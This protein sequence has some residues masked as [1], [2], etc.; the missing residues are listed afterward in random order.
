MHVSG[1]TF[2]S[3]SAVLED[4]WPEDI[5]FEN[6]WPFFQAARDFV[7]AEATAYED[8]EDV[9]WRVLSMDLSTSVDLDDRR[10]HEQ[11]RLAFYDLEAQLQREPDLESRRMSTATMEYFAS[12]MKLQYK[13]EAVPDLERIHRRRASGLEGG[14]PSV[15]P[16][17]TFISTHPT[18]QYWPAKTGLRLSVRRGFMASWMES[19]SPR[20]PPRRRSFFN[21]TIT[22]RPSKP[23][24]TRAW[25][26]NTLGKIDFPACRNRVPGPGY[27]VFSATCGTTS[28]KPAVS[29]S[30]PA[31]VLEDEIE[32]GWFKE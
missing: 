18:A 12:C 30:H 7:R 27:S 13:E 20:I 32:S 5:D 6:A 8:V 3:V 26:A 24:A 2:D 10:S 15:C 21:S 29:A 17:R 31:N 23:L 28:P 11:T 25:Q 14:R 22:S 1:A 9:V 4:Q 16:L 19:S